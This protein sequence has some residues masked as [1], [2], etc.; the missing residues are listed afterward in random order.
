MKPS[1]QPSAQWGRR[2]ALLFCFFCSLVG[3]TL[4]YRRTQQEA[5]QDRRALTDLAAATG[6]ANWVRCSG[7]WLNDDASD[8]VCDWDLVGCDGGGRVKLLTLSFNNLSGTVPASIANLTHLQDL[9]LEYNSLAGSVPDVSGL[10][11]LTQLG[12]GGNG[13]TGPLPASICSVL[14]SVTNN[15]SL[16]TP[17]CDLSGSA[18]ACPLPCPELTGLCGATCEAGPAIG[19][20]GHEREGP[21]HG[22]TPQDNDSQ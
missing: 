15:G 2:K 19:G 17:A 18:F 11:A 20:S 13:F 9:D 1:A 21:E 4:S 16:A 3:P 8:D 5:D 6:A 14:S 10:K 7:G 12:L 22:A